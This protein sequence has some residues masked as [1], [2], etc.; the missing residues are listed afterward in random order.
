MCNVEAVANK[1]K[2]KGAYTLSA[3]F[4][5]W[6]NGEYVGWIFP[7]HCPAMRKSYEKRSW[8]AIVQDG[9]DANPRVQRIATGNTKKKAIK[10]ALQKSPELT[11]ALL[12]KI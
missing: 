9:T 10:A 4:S 11:N 1:I 6:L 7:E 3:G 12:S 8:K 5:L 2:T